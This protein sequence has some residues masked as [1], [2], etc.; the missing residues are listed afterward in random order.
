MSNPGAS[1][2]VAP[3]EPQTD[4]REDALKVALAR[5]EALL[6]DGMGLDAYTEYVSTLATIQRAKDTRWG[7]AHARSARGKLSGHWSTPRD[8]LAEVREVLIAHGAYGPG[9]AVDVAA[10]PGSRVAE[11]WFGQFHM[12]A[13]RRDALAAHYLDWAS[14]DGPSWLNAPYNR[15]GDFAAKA[16]QYRNER[17]PLA[18]LSFARTDTNWFHK[19]VVGGNATV[20]VRKGR[21]AFVD[22]TT[23]KKGQVAP[24]PSLLALFSGR[25]K[26]VEPGTRVGP[27]LCV[28]AGGAA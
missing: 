12:D 2:V 15:I 16:A 11:Q 10:D 3:S 9:F 5:A 19:S 18:F 8:V 21:I 20:W 4:P 23:G 24:A 28:M 22:P 14:P 6:A 26:R 7:A 17:W 1:V 27:W 13:R 25:L